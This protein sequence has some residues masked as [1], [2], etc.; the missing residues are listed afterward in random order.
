VLSV[1]A[2]DPELTRQLAQAHDRSARGVHLYGQVTTHITA[3][4]SADTPPATLTD[5]LDASHAGQATNNTNQALNTGPAGTRIVATLTRER[6]F[7][8]WKVTDLQTT[9]DHCT[10]PNQ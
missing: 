9:P 6:D 8:P 1:V 2:A 3:I 7:G 5:C 4:R 10:H